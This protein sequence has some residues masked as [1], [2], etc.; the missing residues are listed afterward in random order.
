MKRQAGQENDELRPEYDLSRLGGGTKGKYA[1]HYGEGARAPGYRFRAETQAL[2][3]AARANVAGQFVALPDG[4][5]HYELA[6]PE[7]AQPVVLV[8]G[9]SVPY[10]IW[11][12]TFRALSGAGFRT[13]RYDLYG[14]GYSDRPDAVYNLDLFERQLLNLLDALSIARPVDVVGLSMGGPIALTLADRHPQRVR[15]L[16]LIDPAGFP[17]PMPLAS[18]LLRVPGLGEALFD[19]FGDRFLVSDLGKDFCRPERF[20]EYQQQ[21]LAPMRFV[22]FRCALLSTVRNAALDRS[23]EVYARVG[24]QGRPTLLLW[25]RQDRTIPF[26]THLKVQAAIPHAEFHAIDQAGHI[27]HYERPEVVNPLLVE[28]LQR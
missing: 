14:R 4:V 28:F 21:Y 2:D 27:P 5:V 23:A 7:Q 1:R 8:H 20:P 26:S 15:K 19:W 17:M 16:V 12:P 18:H 25:G 6:G 3:D 22:G 24:H 11:D 10:Y 13:L 9:F